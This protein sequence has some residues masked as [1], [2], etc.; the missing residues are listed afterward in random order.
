M[1]EKKK[2]NSEYCVQM[3]NEIIWKCKVNEG[4]K[5]QIRKC[6]KQIVD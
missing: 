3:K 4:Q 1:C 5:Y 6:G 2:M